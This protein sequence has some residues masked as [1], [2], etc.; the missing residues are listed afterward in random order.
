[1]R[2]PSI[3]DLQY[4][5][6]LSGDWSIARIQELNDSKTPIFATGVA[7]RKRMHLGVVKIEAKIRSRV[8]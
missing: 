8:P 3:L 7:R 6:S 1:M 5:L 2:R 4:L